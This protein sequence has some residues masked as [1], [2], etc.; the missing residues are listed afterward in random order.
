MSTTSHNSSQTVN[1]GT[2][3]ELHINE[4][5]DLA[6][7]Q[8]RVLIGH[9]PEKVTT[10]LCSYCGHDGD[11]W[12]P[13]IPEIFVGPHTEHRA[14]KVWSCNDC[15]QTLLLKFSPIMA[16]R[17]AH[18]AEQIRSRNAKLLQNF[19]H[20]PNPT[21]SELISIDA[22]NSR[23]RFLLARLRVL[24][25]GGVGA[26]PA[27]WRRRILENGLEDLCDQSLR[28]D[29]ES[30]T[31]VGQVPNSRHHA[32]SKASSRTRRHRPTARKLSNTP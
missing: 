18:I 6:N 19:V 31:T 13:L 4:A 11:T 28:E 9:L 8:Y 27:T 7:S 25:R 21:A 20:F 3:H 12:S 14:P 24:D 17:C 5:I 15:H 10:R 1:H 26:V 16:D 22:S 2:E 30:D 29:Q 23:R 32:T